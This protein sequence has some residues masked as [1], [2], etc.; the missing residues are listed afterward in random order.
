MRPTTRLLLGFVVLIGI[1][2]AV[3]LGLPAH[4]T[5]SRN[6]VI[7]APESAV[8]PYLNNLHSFSDWSPW[9]ARDPQLQVSFS[10]PETGK[11]AQI[12]W[13]SNLPSVGTGTMQID[14]ADPNRHID[15]AVN[16]NGLEGTSSYDVAPA[17]SGSKVT[18]NFGYD[19]GSSPFKRWKA[20]MLD[21]FVGAEYRTGLDRL[22]AKIEEERRPMAPTVG[23][24]PEGGAS[25]QPEQPSA[26]LP[27][28]AQPQQG[29]AA[30][31]QPAQGGP[32]QT[33]TTPAQAQSD[34]VQSAPPVAAPAPA[35]PPKKR[36]RR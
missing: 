2:A 19:S 24:V 5:V 30:P 22:K 16:F 6:V 8:F 32:A 3:A 33:G 7:N 15:L 26:A 10:G 27:P 29:A 12:Q 34:A 11:G 35:A 23:V 36:R 14:Q 28:G 4:V 25:S 31:G 20:L 21:G 17:G 18:W 1:L 9:R 13:T